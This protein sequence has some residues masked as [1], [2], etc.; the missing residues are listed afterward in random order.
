MGR[1]A[2]KIKKNQQLLIKAWN[3]QLYQ[4]ITSSCL[5]SKESIE[6]SF[7]LDWVKN[8]IALYA[9]MPCQFSPQEN[10]WLEDK[11]VWAGTG[12]FP[13]PTSLGVLFPCNSAQTK[14]KYTQVPHVILRGLN[15]L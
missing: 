5:K 15:F 12:A 1:V 10:E 13:L 3:F 4:K 14:E 6:I 8:L 2:D 11:D 9:L 7:L